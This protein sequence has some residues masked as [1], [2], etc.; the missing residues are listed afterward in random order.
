MGPEDNPA[1]DVEPTQEEWDAWE[2]AYN[3]APEVP[4]SPERIAEIVEY[5][6]TTC[7][8]CEGRGRYYRLP[9]DPGSPCGVCDGTGK[10]APGGGPGRPAAGG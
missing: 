3:E 6:T 8:R 4:L 1:D 7:P 10:M 2:R 9:G 5:A